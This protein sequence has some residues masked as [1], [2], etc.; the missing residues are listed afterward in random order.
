[1]PVG[2]AGRHEGRALAREC[3]RGGRRLIVL[4]NTY[5]LMLRPG[6]EAPSRALG[7]LQRFTTWKRPDADGFSGRPFQVMSAGGTCAKLDEKGR[8]VPFPISM[9][10]EGRICRRSA[11]SRC[12]GLLGSDIAMQLER[13]RAAAGRSTPISSGRCGPVRC[14]GAE[15]FQARLRDGG[16]KAICCSA[17]CP[18]GGDVPELRQQSASR[19]RRDRPSTAMPLAGLAVGEPQAG[20][21]KNDRGDGRRACLSI[22]R[23]YLMGRRHAP[24]IWLEAGPSAAI[25]MFRFALMPDAQWPPHGVAF[26]ALRPRSTCAKRPAHADDPPARSTR[27]AHGRRPA[28][29]RRA[30]PSPPS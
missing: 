7:G 3:A 9:G 30:L 4:G 13:V 2:T 20:D 17:I 21:A 11:R 23:R 18:R 5:H 15:T 26:T 27:K 6:A 1:M 10:S 25:D 19:P 14:A 28:T 12:S 22:G 29:S 16:R 24:R 8:D